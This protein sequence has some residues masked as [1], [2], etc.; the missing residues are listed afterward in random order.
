MGGAWHRN[1]VRREPSSGGCVAQGIFQALRYP[2]QITPP[3]SHSQK[4][5]AG[6]GRMGKKKNQTSSHHPWNDLCLE[7]WMWVSKLQGTRSP[8]HFNFSL[9]I[10]EH[11]PEGGGGE[12]ELCVA[13]EL[14]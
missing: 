2:P 5:V 12:G 9:V 14:C 13:G 6:T 4:P 8:S 3:F 1:G 11:L 10:P 7:G